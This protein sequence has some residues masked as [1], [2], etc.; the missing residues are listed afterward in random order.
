LKERSYPRVEGEV[1]DNDIY[2]T[3]TTRRA[4]PALNGMKDTG[5]V[6]QKG[7]GGIRKAEEGRGMDVGELRKWQLAVWW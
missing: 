1:S 2:G 5:R 6:V 3:Q 4:T 7:D